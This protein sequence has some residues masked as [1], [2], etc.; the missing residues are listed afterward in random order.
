MKQLYALFCLVFVFFAAAQAQPATPQLQTPCVVMEGLMKEFPNNFKAYIG[1][2]IEVDMFSQQDARF[3]SKITIPGAR[4]TFFYNEVFSKANVFYTKFY[5]GG[6]S[7]LANG[8]FRKWRSKL[9]GC[10]TLPFGT[11]G[12]IESE[13]EYEKKIIWYPFDV[14]GYMEKKYGNLQIEFKIFKWS[15]MK[16]NGHF[17]P[18]YTLEMR[19]LRSS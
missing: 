11:L 2:D 16:A 8:E 19:I 10:T 13:D 15:K 18:V 12:A 1:E 17:D 14:S 3:Q 7:A 5:E 6:D 9:E 4:E